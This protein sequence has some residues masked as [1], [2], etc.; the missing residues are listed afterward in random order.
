M[1]NPI[2]FGGMASGMDTE[3]IVKQLMASERLKV[4]RFSQQKIWKTWQQE[5]YSGLN[6]MMANF[7]LDS[8]K[9]LELSRT[10]ATGSIVGGSINS[11]SWVNKASS[12]NESRFSASATASAAQGNYSLEINKLA[13]GIKASTNGTIENNQIG[14]DLNISVNGTNVEL[15]STDT[16]ADIARKIN[17]VSGVTA[18]Y[19]VG[20]QKFFLA[21]TQ[22]GSESKLEIAGPDANQLLGILD[23]KITSGNTNFVGTG[24]ENNTLSAIPG[25]TFDGDGKFGLTVN[26]N[27]IILNDTDTIADLATKM[28]NISGVTA[29]Y[30]EASKKFFIESSNGNLN[31]EGAN[32]GVLLGL[33]G[34]N[35][36]ES[37]LV[38]G[39]EYKGTNA[40]IVF[41]GATIEYQTNNISIIGIN[42]SL[43]SAA[44]GVVENINVSTDVDG[45][46]DKI[47]NFVDEYNKIIDVFNAKTGEKVYRDFP[48]LTDE[49][50]SAM[51]ETDIKLWED[52]AKSGLL[53]DDQ[54]LR[55][56]MQDIRRDLYEPVTNAGA[57]YE[58]GITTGSWRDNG[59]L[60]IDEQKLKDALRNDPEKV[61]NTLFKTSNISEV[62]INSDDSDEVKEQKRAQMAARKADTG[63]F[64]R[65]FDNMITGMKSIIDRSGPG[66]EGTLLRSVR[67]NIM[68][69]YV[70]KGSKS[71][72]DRD[73]SEIEKR[74]SRENDRL[75]S[76]EQGHWKRF[77]AMEKAMSQMN[78]QSSWLTQQFAG[79]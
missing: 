28:N 24:I 22:T 32:A 65:V 63:A 64:V 49:Q 39:T 52:K 30:D 4:D 71:L 46:F 26:G 50:R 70:T 1:I 23:L 29:T 78:N 9:S 55:G 15:I 67:S 35:L 75:R 34:L 19:D 72:L 69:D 58:L 45:A 54:I 7:I 66:S 3:G 16:I 42:I 17:N 31:I 20:S 57:I 10:T 8:R 2:R 44:P 33:D 73:M 61:M 79:N 25:L 60:V 11:A 41:D 48:P 51:S 74:I 56:T 47:K 68:V 18:R 62:T 13:D 36:K 6:K 37:P 53:R 40:E 76:I 14:Q 43:K 59:K 5:Q 77:T 27:E 12:S 21:S 38:A